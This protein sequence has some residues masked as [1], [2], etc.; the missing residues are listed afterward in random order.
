[1]AEKIIAQH[2]G[3]PQ[4]FAGQY[5]DAKVDLLMA[6][7]AC[8]ELYDVFRTVGISEV[9]DPLKVIGL[10]DHEV[11]ASTV[12]AAE[13]DKLRRAFVNEFGLK[14]WYDVGRGGICHQVLPEKG[15]VVPGS[16][17]VGCDSHTTSYGA[18]NAAG[19]GIPVVEAYW[20]AAK[21]SLW[22]RVPETILFEI[23]GEMPPYVM[24]KDVALYIAGTY[25][26]DFAN[27][28]SIEFTGEGVHKMSL[29]SRWTIAN[30]GVELG[31]KF[32]LFAYD[33]KTAEFLAG[34][35]TAAFTPVTSDCDAVFESRH[36]LDV[37]TLRP[38][39]A[40]PHE[41]GNVHLA[42]DLAD[43][44]I[45]QAFL[46]SCTGGR[47]EDLKIAADILRGRKVAPHVRLIVMPASQE[48]YREA[49]TSGVLHDLID[50]DASIGPCSCGPCS[51]YHSGL[52]AANERCVS[53]SSRNF[54][55]RMGSA[56]S[57]IFLASPA[58]VAA[59]A[60]TG[61]IADPSEL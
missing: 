45:A 36:S 10:V 7:D 46:G 47:F 30:M 57:E 60:L 54:R 33:N 31:A 1:M 3:L 48:V 25:G 14:H 37:S 15:H 56:D 18:F 51:G 27:Y 20:V 58:T 4:V 29:S 8:A 52:L 32:A 28:K 22:F 44:R 50:A 59:S 21:G 11:P 38:L 6:G 12:L 41:V 2:A 43:I 49:L 53:S 9:W 16:L 26:T 24:G 39:V 35:T 19:T 61:Y 17:I 34:R 55:G 13:Q 5:V 23:T 42:R 40:C